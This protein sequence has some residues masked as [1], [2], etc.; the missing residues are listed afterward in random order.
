MVW[1]GLS[2]HARSFA[3]GAARALARN[4]RVAA[5]IPAARRAASEAFKMACA[6]PRISSV[7]DKVATPSAGARVSDTHAPNSSPGTIGRIIEDVRFPRRSPWVR[8]RAD[9]RYGL[10]I[11][12]SIGHTN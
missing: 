7:I 4:S 1:R 9:L 8:Q 6:D 12:D 10:G 11:L 3:V 2:S 5:G